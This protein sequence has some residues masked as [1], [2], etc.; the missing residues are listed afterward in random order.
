LSANVLLVEG[1][2]DTYY[3][4]ING[5]MVDSFVDGAYSGGAFGL[6]ADNF[7]GEQSVTFFFDD[8]VMG[9]PVIE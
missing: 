7:D 9:T 4:Y 8:Y 1:W 5:Q 6:I 2:G 3:V